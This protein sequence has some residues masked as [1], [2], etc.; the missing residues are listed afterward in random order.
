MASFVSLLDNVDLPVYQ[1]DSSTSPTKV[2][3]QNQNTA[4]PSRDVDGGRKSSVVFNKKRYSLLARALHDFVSQHGM[5]PR[6]VEEVLSILCDALE[7]DPNATVYTT[8]QLQKKKTAYKQKLAENNMNTWDAYGKKY[9]DKN[10]EACI[11]RIDACRKK[12]VCN[13]PL[14]DALIPN[15]DYQGLCRRCYFFTYPDSPKTKCFK[16]KEKAVADYVRE[17]FPRLS[18]QLDRRVFDGCSRR[19][20]DILVDMGS[21][22]IIIEVDEHRHETYDSICEN[23]RLMEIFRDLGCNRPLVVIRFNPDSY[24]DTTTGANIKSCWMSS[25]GMTCLKRTAHADWT[26]RLNALR[27]LIDR[28]L[29]TVPNREVTVEHLFFD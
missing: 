6:R 17:Q 9:Y 12:R 18:W 5:P 21:H 1:S 28:H 29:H 2:S 25:R 11:E 13:T 10:R 24:V 20:P 3:N 19:R 16:A 23:R 4:T 27:G 26:A 7:F 14:C 22:V 8:E 15:N